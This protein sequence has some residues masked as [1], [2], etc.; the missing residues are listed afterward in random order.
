MPDVFIYSKDGDSMA[1]LGQRL[2]REGH[3]VRMFTFNKES[4]LVG[5]GLVPKAPTGIPRK[6]ELVIFDTTGFGR[7]ADRLRRGGWKVISGGVFADRLEYDRG[8][9][10]QVMRDAGIPVPETHEFKTANE[11]RMFLQGR[12]PGEAWYIKPSGDENCAATYGA[13]DIPDMLREL[14]FRSAKREMPPA[15]LLQKKMDS[16]AE[17]SFEGWF[18]G[19]RWV[20]P[21]NSTIEDKKLLAGDLGPN[22]G[23]MANL[24]W[25]Y[26]DP[27]PRLATLTLTRLIPIL[28]EVQYTGPIDINGI[29]DAEGVYHALEFTPRPGYLALQALVALTKGDLGAQLWEFANGSL[30]RFAVATDM[31]S[32]AVGVSIP[33]YPN[34]EFAS[35]ARG[36]PLDP[37]LLYD[38][39]R[40]MLTDVMLIDGKPFITG[41]DASVAAFVDTGKGLNELRSMVLDNI[42]RYAIRNA[43]YRN[44][45]VERAEQEFDFL[46]AK[47]YEIPR[48]EEGPP[49]RPA[50]YPGAEPMPLDTAV[51]ASKDGTRIGGVSP[52]VTHVGMDT[53]STIEAAR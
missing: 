25:A 37:K 1:P 45:P 10:I 53:T 6:G 41:S 7:E 52:N 3:A 29:F 38:P 30:D 47:G 32:L 48:F 49:E 23:C 8:F 46:E 5:D 13:R 11:A 36:T 43:Q 12:D 19:R 39:L 40:V 20:L 27:M 28:R 16:S 50:E 2:L 51:S 14:D 21:W 22:T 44:D 17:L 18:D 26:E 34:A 4:K 42:S 33:P 31:F 35:V 9:G 15:F 24:V